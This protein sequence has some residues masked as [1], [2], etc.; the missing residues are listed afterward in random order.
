[1]PPR[2]HAENEAWCAVRNPAL[3]DCRFYRS[4][5][6]LP[7]NCPWRAQNPP[8]VHKKSK[9]MHSSLVPRVTERNGHPHI[10]LSSSPTLFSFTEQAHAFGGRT[11]GSDQGH[12]L[13]ESTTA[14]ETP[15]GVSRARG[16]NGEGDASST[17]FAQGGAHSLS[18][19]LQHHKSPPSKLAALEWTEAQQHQAQLVS[20]NVPRLLVLGVRFTCVRACLHR[21]GCTENDQAVNDNPTRA[22]VDKSS[23]PPLTHSILQ[24]MLDMKCTNTTTTG[25]RGAARVIYGE[26]YCFSTSSLQMTEMGTC[27]DVCLQEFECPGKPDITAM[28]EKLQLTREELLNNPF[29]RAFCAESSELQFLMDRQFCGDSSVLRMLRSGVP[30]WY[31]LPASHEMGHLEHLMCFGPCGQKVECLTPLT[32]IVL[33]GALGDLLKAVQQHLPLECT[34]DEVHGRE[35]YS[36]C[37]TKTRLG[38][39][40]QKW[41]SQTPHKHEALKDQDHNFCRAADGAKDIWCFTTDPDVRSDYCQALGPKTQVVHPQEVFDIVL[42]G[43]FYTPT[44]DIAFFEGDEKLE[45]PCVKG[46]QTG[47][48]QVPNAVNSTVKRVKPVETDGAVS[49]LIWEGATVGESAKGAYAICLCDYTYFI[50]N[51]KICSKPSDFTLHVGWLQVKGEARR[52]VQRRATI[53][54]QPAGL[55][56]A[57]LACLNSSHAGQTFNLQAGRP[58]SLNLS[59]YG[60]QEGDTVSIMQTPYECDRATFTFAEAMSGL[61]QKGPE[62]ALMIQKALEIGAATAAIVSSTSVYNKEQL[63]TMVLPEV[64]VYGIGTFTACWRSKDNTASASAATIVVSGVELRRQFYALYVAKSAGVDDRPFAMF[65]KARGDVKKPGANDIY[66]TLVGEDSCGGTVVGRSQDVSEITGGKSEEMKY[67]VAEQITVSNL[68]NSEGSTAS[69][70]GVCMDTEGEKVLLG[71]AYVSRSLIY[72]LESLQFGLEGYTGIPSYIFT[73]SINKFSALGLHWNNVQSDCFYEKDLTAFFAKGDFPKALSYWVGPSAITVWHSSISRPSPTPFAKFEVSGARAVGISA[74]TE[75]IVFFI[76]LTNPAR[77]ES[78]DMTTPAN[79]WELSPTAT[80]ADKLKLES[81]VAMSILQGKSRTLVVVVDTKLRQ[82]LLLDTDLQPLETKSVWDGMIRPLENPKSIF[83]I[84]TP[85]RVSPEVFDCYITD[86]RRDRLIL[87]QYDTSTGSSSFVS[88]VSEGDD[89]KLTSPHVVL[90]HPFSGFTLIYVAEE[91]KAKPMLL[92]KPDGQSEI[93]L[94]QRLETLSAGEVDMPAICLLQTGHDSDGLNSVWLMAFHNS[95]DGPFVSLVPLDTTATAPEFKY[96]PREWYALGEEHKLE[97]SIV[98]EGSSSGLM[99]FSLNGAA[100]S[101]PFMERNVSIDKKTGTLTLSLVDIQEGSVTVEVIGS[102]IVNSVHTS[103]SFRIGCRDGH[104]FKQG[105]CIKCP[106]GTFNSLALVKESPASYFH[107]CRLCEGKT[108]TLA[109]GSTS[110][111]QCLCEKGYHRDEKVDANECTPCPE[112]SY[113]DMVANSGC[114][115]GGC[116]Q[117]SVSHVVGAVSSAD[118]KCSCLP[119]HYAVHENDDLE[120]NQVEVG[121]FSLG[122]YEA[123]RV[124]CPPFTS[125]NKEGGLATDITHCLCEPGFAPANSESLQ[126]LNSPA[127][128]LKRWILLNPA[129]KGLDDSQVCMPCGRRHYK[130]RV[131]AEQCIE[132]PTNS[133]SSVDSPTNKSSC[134]MCIPGYYLTSNEDLPCGE[135]QSNHFCVGS[136]PSVAG[137]EQFAGEKVPCSE[138]TET[139]EP[140][141]QNKD[142]FSCMCTAGYEFKGIDFIT[143]KV[144]CNPVALGEYK[145]SLGNLQGA[146]C[147]PGSYTLRPTSTS[148]A[149]CVCNAGYYLDEES[150]ICQPCPVGAY[151]LGGLNPDTNRHSGF[152]QCPK[153]TTTKDQMSTSVSDCLCDK[154]F[155]HSSTS[156]A[157]EGPSCNVCS[158]NSYKDWIGNEA[159]KQCSENSETNATGSTSSAQCLCRPG[160]YYSSNFRECLACK[161][162]AKYC[163]GGEM[164][165]T[166][167]DED[168]VGGKKPIQPI[169]CP[170]HTRITEGFDTPSTLDDCKCER[171]YAFRHVDL[172]LQTKVCEPCN[173]GSYKSTIQDINCNGLCGVSSTSL[174]GAQAQVQCFCE[175]GTY[176]ATG[177]CHT[178]PDGAVCSGGLS[179]Y[180]IS[181]LQKDPSYVSIT[182]EDHVKPYSQAGYYLNKLNDKLESPSD[183]Q[184]LQC[185]IENA[186]LKFGV[187]SATMTDYLCSECK[188]GYTNG[189]ENDTICTACPNMVP[190]ALL[191][192][193]YQIALLLFNIGMAYMNV[194]AGFNRRSIHSVVIK[195]ASNFITCMSVLTVV[196]YNQINL[197][198]WLTSITNTVSETIT[199][200]ETS[201]HMMAVECLLREGFNL[202]YADSFFYTM[203]F[204]ALLPVCLPFLV[205]FL[206]FFLLNRFKQYYRNSIKKKLQLLE[207]T[208]K[209]GLTSLTEQLRE[210]YEEDRAF[211]MFRYIPIP[212]D[213]QWRRF[214][215]FVEDMI[216]IYVTVLFFLYTATTRHMLSLLDC[217]MIDFGTTHGSKYFLSSAMSVECSVDPSKEYFKFFALGI[218]GIAVWSIGIPLT[219]TD[220]NGSILW[221]ASVIAVVFNIYH[222][223][224]Q[225]FDKRSYSTLDN[226]EN[227]SMSIWTLTICVM[228]AISGSNFSGNVNLSLAIIVVV[229]IVLFALEVAVNLLFAYFD[230]VRVNRSFF[231]VPVLGYLFRAFARWSEKRKSWEPIVVYDVENDIIQLVAA[232]KQRN[233]KITKKLSL[234]RINSRERQYFIK[235]MAETLGFAV[236]HMKL[237]VIPGTFLEFV[238]RLGFAF[239]KLDEET[240]ENKKSLQAIEGGDIAMLADWSH[241]QSKELARRDEV[242]KEEVAADDCLEGFFDKIEEKI[243]QG[244]IES[245]RLADLENGLSASE[246]DEEEQEED[247]V[248]AAGSEESETEEEMGRT[249]KRGKQKVPPKRRLDDKSTFKQSAPQV[250]RLLSELSREEQQETRYIFDNEVMGCGI[251]LS[252][253]YLALLKLQ[254]KE[255]ASISHQFEIFRARKA[256]YIERVAQAL[257]SRNRK[258]KLIRYTLQTANEETADEDIAALGF[259]AGAFE[260]MKKRVDALLKEQSRMS[261]TLQRLR[262]DPDSYQGEDVDIEWMDEQQQGS[263]EGTKDTPDSDDREPANSDEGDEVPLSSYY[264]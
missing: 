161:S 39:V 43:S 171:G 22:V 198:T 231:G 244:D 12:C 200:K 214:T 4:S 186:C 94:Y 194:A 228:M 68:S 165:C 258:L 38:K 145:D 133:F 8:D 16:D 52:G 190:N 160:Y 130:G 81:P 3:G 253:L 143:N 11:P 163:P 175:E 144:V 141:R 222:L 24:S 230:N 105:M 166:D 114:T 245:E 225:P 42:E 142:P 82:V 256:A 62:A 99:G 220:V 204:H 80:T 126:D 257:R 55:A 87:L 151:C 157:S 238:L 88:E 264:R 208:E 168:C 37:Q 104:Y 155:Y 243:A 195:I 89:E 10:L 207:E 177:S 73:H 110:N 83:C 129:Y 261:K 136:E 29:I 199:Q 170:D 203:L 196:D 211:M 96:T 60:Y 33:D 180:A 135:C 98:G 169:D 212:G 224:S 209:Y 20:A 226:L 178:C 188:Y 23:D 69:T 262:D 108:T 227:H 197:P 34:C 148:L 78:Y 102:G 241:Q 116:P 51:T 63:V 221:P 106:T 27:V 59:G 117:F 71:Y 18:A 215:K 167:D 125:T 147:P 182:S 202:S 57:F 1:M 150:K 118:R 92:T 201:T 95:Y 162:T 35:N 26:V 46:H 44:F 210:R 111:E 193:L 179:D 103:F 47:D 232:K 32:P 66:L 41:N 192:V 115:G 213:S 64:T 234:S 65:I 139:V 112:G 134:N 120:C 67:F 237:D 176:Y 93:Q 6:E 240:Q 13:A 54:Q 152:V 17:A 183:W 58:A 158:V 146:S 181:A 91:G 235:V 217:K 205:T 109:E 56:R 233:L 174:V 128:M 185:P 252:E 45:E 119:G 246:L 25:G 53:Q 259:T 5:K 127:S 242:T 48:I 84:E 249:H 156:A 239:Q 191:L 101:Y 149:D 189:F 173:A 77:I 164:D 187:C 255:S 72:P 107:Q 121:Y 123:Q 137:L 260:E 40:C 248:D 122:G 113:K 154:G 218:V 7:Q 140:N 263:T 85:S 138:N 76:A 9:Q 131:S 86:P 70:L 50:G 229:A 61:I 247:E 223:K 184:F 36:G 254:L 49:G 90:A 124:Q 251:P 28:R 236:V 100:Q 19:F 31:C 219:A 30:R 250:E 75:S 132:C 206:L 172:N 15:T 14:C 159:C 2:K 153:N 79:I 21:V 74:T 216:P 97:P